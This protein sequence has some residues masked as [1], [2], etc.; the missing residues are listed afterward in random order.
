MRKIK[1][2]VVDDSLL[3]R[4]LL[5]ESLRADPSIEVVAQAGDEIGRAS[6]RER[7]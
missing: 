4:N 2:L 3:F 7:G 6:C 5:V 1:V